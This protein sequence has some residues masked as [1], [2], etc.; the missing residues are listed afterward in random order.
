MLHPV[1][2]DE[3]ILGVEESNGLREIATL[4]SICQGI[5]TQRNNTDRSVPG[6]L[7]GK[8]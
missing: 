3:V 6:I 1:S 7:A 2:A 4:P 8:L 5:K